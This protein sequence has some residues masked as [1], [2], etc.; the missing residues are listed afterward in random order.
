MLSDSEILAC[1]SNGEV[2]ISPFEPRNL[3]P[4]SYDVT[5]G[6]FYYREQPCRADAVFNIYSEAHVWG[7][8]GGPIE[9]LT[10]GQLRRDGENIA[11]TDRV[12]LLGPGESILAHT[13]EFIGG[14]SNVTSM[15]KARSSFGRCFITVCRCA[16][17]GDV[18][19]INRWTME[20]TN[21][22]RYYHI[23]L[24][25]GRRV[26][27]IT[28]FRTGAATYYADKG[29]YQSSSNLDQLRADWRPAMMLPR[30]HRDWELR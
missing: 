15:M 24:V 30:L 29:K 12:I 11:P 26:A 28:F 25:V 27:Q 8:W 22:S 21:N 7:V 3:G 13:N 23:P 14:R 10:A 20:I 18:G 4:N 1:M 19:Y 17:M 9:A 6:E 5:L 2:V 16:G